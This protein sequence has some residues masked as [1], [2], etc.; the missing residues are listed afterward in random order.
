MG[1]AVNYAINQWP[2]LIAYLDC[3]ELTADN[4]KAEQSINPFVMGRKNLLFSGSPAGTKS[5]CFL[6]SFIETAK[7]N[8]IEPADYLRCLFEQAPLCNEESEFE[9]LLP[10]NITIS[11]FQNKCV[12]YFFSKVCY[13]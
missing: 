9:Q 2:F 13:N 8:D 7:A 6:Y 10:W 4:N 3:A 1:K 11:K 5:S 12:S